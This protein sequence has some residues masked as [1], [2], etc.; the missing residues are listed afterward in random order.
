MRPMNSRYCRLLLSV[1]AAII[2]SCG[3]GGGQP[4]HAPELSVVTTWHYDNART[5]VNA[6]ET[7][8]TLANVNPDT[9]GKLF[10]IPVDGAI[11]GQVLYL[12]NLS[13]PGKGTHNVV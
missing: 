3:G 13:I 1:F 4:S 9:F 11:I 10:D 12:S 6:N 7:I 8:L 2:C 5:G